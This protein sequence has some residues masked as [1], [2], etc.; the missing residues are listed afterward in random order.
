[1][2]LSQNKTTHVFDISAKIFFA[3]TIIFISFR[4]RVDIWLRPMPPVYS[5]YTNF[6]LFL[7]DITL[8]Y[9][10][11]FWLACLILNPKKIKAGNP[12]IWIGLIGLTISGV[13]SVFG[14]VDSIL[15]QYHVIRFI[16]LL[17]LYLY[18]VN[19]VQSP[20]WVIVPIALQIII[21]APVA[22][23][24]SLAQSSLGL[25]TFGEILLDPQ[26][27]GT[28]IIPIDGIRFL[29]AYG[30]SDHPNILGGSIAFSLIILFA[31]VLYGKNRQPLFA[32]ILFL[33]SFPALIM[34]FSRS[35]WLGLMVSISFMV[36]VEAFARR[37]ESIQRIIILS[38]L[39][40]IVI[41]PFSLENISV[42]QKRINAGNL[43]QDEPMKERG[44]LLQAGNTLFIEHPLLGIGLS[45]TPFAF[46]RRFE[47]F[48]LSYQPPHY[49]PLLVPLET[50]VLGG[51]FY[52]ILF[53][54]PFIY[55]AIKRKEIINNPYVMGASALLVTISVISLFDYYTWYVT[56]RMWHWLAWG[57]FSV[58]IE[59]EQ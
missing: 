47:E 38:L 4:W 33:I 1:M 31:V 2:L 28:S 17:L 50:G 5:D 12:L 3:L 22:I 27:L 6:Q 54:M 45:A 58:A 44:F 23:R 7:S 19:E 26:I 34:T 57:L 43:A 21:Q 9:L 42:F 30:L 15:S 20:V 29:R 11:T 39:S 24:Q 35:A 18:I 40:L 48:P 13:I 55:F 16:L 51:I 37:W 36:S 25:Q 14:S 49:V 52:L 59:R 32:S 53:F 8:I 41:M 56:G 10:L 46:E